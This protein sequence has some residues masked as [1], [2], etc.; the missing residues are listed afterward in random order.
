MT[1][2]TQSIIADDAYMRLR[3]ASCAAQEGCTEV[4]I[5]PDMWTFDW[6]RVWASAPDWDAAWESA[7]A[8]DPPLD[9][10]GKDEGVIT[11]GMITA[12]V[13][14][15]LPFTMVADHKLVVEPVQP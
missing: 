3:V 13:Q 6:R 1:Y 5:D 15:M 9:E 14:A 7:M 2:L 8:A 10:P 11:D 4:G 12:Q